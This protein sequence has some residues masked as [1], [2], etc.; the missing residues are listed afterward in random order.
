MCSLDKQCPYVHP[1]SEVLTWFK[2]LHT[3]I[4]VQTEREFL[5]LHS[6]D[7]WDCLLPLLADLAK[8]EAFHSHWGATNDGDPLMLVLKPHYSNVAILG[9]TSSGLME[10]GMA[11]SPQL[12]MMVA[13]TSPPHEQL[14]TLQ[15]LMEDGT[16]SSPQPQAMTVVDTSPS[17]KQLGFLHTPSQNWASPY[18]CSH[19][20]HCFGGLRWGTNINV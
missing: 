2:A 18:L 14:C 11:S 1:F 6:K 5:A 7:P 8:Y 9:S 3:L 20:P 16:A 15:G 17:Y 4:A 19:C 12:E 13:D 10:G